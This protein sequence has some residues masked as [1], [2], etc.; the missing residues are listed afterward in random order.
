M[1]TVDHHLRVVLARW[2]LGEV[3][4]ED[5]PQLAI[6]AL[7][8]GCQS[9]SVAV[10]AGLDRPT[11]RDVEDELPALLGELGLSLPSR[12]AA[13]KTVVDDVA[14]EIVVG[15]VAPYQ[16]ARQIWAYEAL[17][18]SEREPKLWEQ[19]RPFIGLASQ[20]E[21]YPDHAAEYDAEIIGEAR[22]L[23]DQGGLAVTE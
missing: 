8:R 3:W 21:D 16:G 12:G 10:I 13:L 11:R 14:R 17:S 23:L 7:L 2:V 6:D 1:L 5:V 19:F 20:R 22:T 15:T 4:P 9:T 18:E